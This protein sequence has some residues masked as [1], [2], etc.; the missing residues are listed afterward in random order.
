LT[1]AKS[2]R[3]GDQQKGHAPKAEKVSRRDNPPNCIANGKK[4]HLKQY[5]HTQINVVRR[6]DV[7]EN[8]VCPQM[9]ELN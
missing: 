3:S 2:W 6:P 5:T 1:Q 7:T 4:R 9:P 8:I